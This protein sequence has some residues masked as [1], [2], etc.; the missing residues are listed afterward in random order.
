MTAQAIREFDRDLLALGSY[1]G[2]VARVFAHA[3]QVDPD[4][5]GAEPLTL[6]ARG[7][8]VVPYGLVLDG[9]LHAAVGDRVCL[10]GR[11]LQL[12]GCSARLEGEGCSLAI[13]ELP[14]ALDLL[15]AQ[16]EALSPPAGG[17]EARPCSECLGTIDHRV[18]HHPHMRIPQPDRCRGGV[19]PHPRARGRVSRLLDRLLAERLAELAQDVADGAPFRP[20]RLAGLGAGST[21][22]GDDALAGLAAG[23]ERLSGLGGLDDSRVRDLRAALAALPAGQTTPLGLRMLRAA[24]RGRYPAPLAALAG[25]LG[26]DEPEALQAAVISLCTLGQTS[27]GDMLAGLAALVRA[28]IPSDRSTRRRG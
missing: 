22:S 13:G 14:G 12:A 19:H 26:R 7:R 27:G 8:P 6:L 28:C 9:R 4:E 10:C 11:R 17:H 3:A 16:L 20:E 23:A 25:C 5:P 15:P 2:A 18:H 21:P 24:S 1:R